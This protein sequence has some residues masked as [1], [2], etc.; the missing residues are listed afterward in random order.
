MANEIVKQYSM[1]SNSLTKIQQ[2]I[3]N[4]LEEHSEGLIRG[5]RCEKNSLMGIL[6]V[7]RTTLYDNLLKLLKRN[8]VEKIKISD[9]KK[10]RPIS[11]WKLKEVK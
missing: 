3:L 8:H 5:Q 6:N 4:V 11:L 9:G 7:P 2:E 10:G 1:N